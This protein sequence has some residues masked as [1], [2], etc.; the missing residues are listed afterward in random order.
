MR[1]LLLRLGAVV[2]LV[3]VASGDARAET[4]GLVF[5]SALQ[6]DGQLGQRGGIVFARADGATSRQVS[7]FRTFNFAFQLHGLDLPDDHA[8]CTPDGRKIAFS[9]SR[10]AAG[11]ALGPNDFDIYTMAPNGSSVRRLTSSPGRDI[12]PAFSPDGAKIAFAS[13]RA[14]GTPHIFVMNADG[15]GVVQLTSG[16]D[17]EAEPAWSPDGTKIAFTRIPFSALGLG[18]TQKDVWIM[19]ADG[20]GQ[21][22]LTD[23]LG[24][25]HDATFSPDGSKIAYSSERT[26]IPSPP[27]GDTFII[28]VARGTADP[29]VNLT[30]DLAFGAGDPAWHP[31]GTRIAFFKAVLPVLT[32]PMQIWT[33]RPDGSDK[34]HVTHAFQDG[35][36]NVHPS[37]CRLVDSDGDGRPDYLEN[38]SRSFSQVDLRDASALAPSGLGSAVAY[39]DLDHDGRLDV[40]ASVPGD[41]VSGLARAGRVLLAR[42]TAFGPETR[43]RGA[44]PSSLTAIAFGDSASANAELGYAMVGCDFDGD[45]FADLAVSAPG[46]NRVYVLRGATGPTQILAGPGRFGH[47]LAAGDF[48]GDGR[49]DLAVGSPNELRPTGVR[50]SVAAGAVRVY[51]GSPNGLSAAPQLLDQARFS[52]GT[53]VD[54]NEEGDGFGSALAAGKLGGDAAAELAIGVPGERIDGVAGAGL[55]VV[56]PGIVGGQLAPQSATVRDARSLASPYAGLVENGRFGEALAI[57]RFSPS[58]GPADLV[59][60]A[61][62]MSPGGIASAGLVATYGASSVLLATGLAQTGKVITSAQVDVA[63]AEGMRFGQAF[64]VGDANGDAIADLAIAAP[65][66]PGATSV[67]G[68]AVYLVPGA[69]ASTTSCMFCGPAIQ[70]LEG[71]LSFSS[72]VKITAGTVSASTNG[73]S[74]GGAAAGLVPLALADLDGDGQADLLVGSPEARGGEGLL[75]VRYGVRTG[76]AVGEARLSPQAAETEPEHDVTYTLEWSHPERWRDL[77]TVHLRLVGEGGYALWVRMREAGDR[78]LLGVASARSGE[79]V[80]AQAGDTLVLDGGG[81]TVDLA[82]AR[83]EGSGPTGRSVRVTF[84]V[85]PTAGLAGQVLRVEV[86]ATDDT[87][88]AQEIETR[89][90]LSVVRDAGTFGG[91]CGVSPPTRA[92]GARGLLGLA[93]LLGVT[94]RARRGKSV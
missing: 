43:D 77:D 15:T 50:R 45:G 36:L 25:D 79:F 91:A 53:E 26:V 81:A 44:V 14:G 52:T 4:H 80:E 94:R 55:I 37:W 18:F 10:D 5:T 62:R 64:A 78:L 49:C 29:G 88:A 40:A 67:G 73:A 54:S 48:N 30:G 63:L 47:A 38:A 85:R 92:A 6:I 28:D 69:P 58:L 59:V 1:S 70:A 74:F 31:D 86:F 51:F 35:L 75:A 16:S 82:R 66:A 19:N 93:V 22:R 56:V 23:T 76:G 60:G 8:S 87:G 57:G 34:V 13:E 7:E 12:T 27:F 20:S 24:E 83:V 46:A 65:G 84:P 17:P 39:A 71:G 41:T 68:G 90:T 72:A 3:V 11:G 9:S 32:S 21:R 33:M 2:A 89:G 42:G 61:P